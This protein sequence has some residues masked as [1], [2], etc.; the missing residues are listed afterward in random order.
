MAKVTSTEVVKAG[1]ASQRAALRNT[2]PQAW[3]HLA[4]I[5]Q[6]DPDNGDRYRPTGSY[7]AQIRAHGAAIG[8]ECSSFV[9]RPGDKKRAAQIVR[10]LSERSDITGI[11]PL[12]PL[13]DIDEVKAHLRPKQDVDGLLGHRPA[14]TA[15]AMKL[16]ANLCLHGADYYEDRTIEE[17]DHLALP[18]DFDRMRIFLGGLG[19]LTCKRLRADLERQGITIPDHRIATLNSPDSLRRMPERALVFTAMP[20]AELISSEDIG[21]DSVVIDGGFGVKGERV[22]GNTAGAVEHRP[23]VLWTPPTEGVGPGSTLYLYHHLLEASGVPLGAMG[24]LA[25]EAAARENDPARNRIPH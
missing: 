10:E 14:P 25:S 23:D 8:V 5:R 18:E 1:Q 4:V 20:G 13:D 22:Y 2:N 3:P 21:P 11:M 24:P 17:L 19:E 7:S 9:V 15:R 12:Y 16:M 6:V